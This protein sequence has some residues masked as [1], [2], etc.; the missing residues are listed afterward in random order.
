[1][2]FPFALGKTKEKENCAAAILTYF[3]LALM[4]ML[5][6][7]GGAP[8]RTLAETKRS[9]LPFVFT[10]IASMMVEMCL[11]PGDLLKTAKLRLSCKHSRFHPRGRR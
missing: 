6:L 1:M 8:G 10:A 7:F 9:S 2:A 5:M 3:A 4:L 11:S